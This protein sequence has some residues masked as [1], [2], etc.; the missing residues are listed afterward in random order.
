MMDENSWQ[1]YFDGHAHEYM[2]QWYTQSWRQEVDFLESE[3]ALAPGSRILDVGCGAGRHTVELARRGYRVTGL[4][5]SAG[6]LAEAEKAAQAAGVEVEWLH[7]DATQFTSQHRY[8]GAICMLEAAIGLI[9]VAGDPHAHNLAVMRNVC[10]VLNVGAKFIMEVPNAVRMLRD[11]TPEAVADGEMDLVR[12]IHTGESTWDAADGSEHG[13]VTS[14]R[15]YVPTELSLMLQQSGFA[16]DAFSGKPT[17]RTPL[18]LE[19]YTLVA[20]AQKV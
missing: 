18:A 19:D 11:L 1:T 5:F 14:T 8:D 20:I 6:M 9:P 15:S 7:A 4:D 13:I 12:M 10:A 17:G 2:T 3:L 16:V